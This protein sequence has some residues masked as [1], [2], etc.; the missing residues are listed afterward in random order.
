MTDAKKERLDQLVK[1]L[2]QVGIPVPIS[3][4][5]SFKIENTIGRIIGELDLL[6][7]CETGGLYAIDYRMV[8]N[9]TSRK[10]AKKKLKQAYACLQEKY[11]SFEPVL[12]YVSEGYPFWVER[13][14]PP[15]FDW[16]NY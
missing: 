4:H 3:I 15:H 8:H 2:K 13:L 12:L 16:S 1:D 9:Q 10:K 5:R 11:P 7:H 14:H 6:V